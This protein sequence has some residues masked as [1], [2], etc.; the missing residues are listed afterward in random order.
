MNIPPLCG[1]TLVIRRGFFPHI[2]PLCG[3][4]PIIRSYFHMPKKVTF[5][6]T[7][8]HV[9]LQDG[10]ALLWDL[11]EGKHLYNLN[12]GEVINALIF[13]PNRYWLCAATGQSV[14]VWVSQLNISTCMKLFY[15]SLA[16]LS[17]CSLSLLPHLLFFFSQDLESKSLVDEI[18]VNHLSTNGPVECMSL[19]WSADGQTLFAGYTDNLIR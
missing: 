8:T 11:N 4:D 7:Q 17:L 3:E 18:L 12:G 2:P 16:L 6:H 10:N 14:K 19:A 9:Y 5:T 1:E 13:S 15:Q